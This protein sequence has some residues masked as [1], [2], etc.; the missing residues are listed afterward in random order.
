MADEDKNALKAETV[1]VVET[2]EQKTTLI[3]NTSNALGS[4]V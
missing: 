2:R 4:M 1:E 3:S